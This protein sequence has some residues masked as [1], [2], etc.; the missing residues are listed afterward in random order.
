MT[1]LKALLNQRIKK[2]DNGSKMA[3]MAKQSATG[4][5]SSFSGIFGSAELSSHE[6]AYLESILQEYNQ[7]DEDVSKDL[8]QLSFITSEVKAINNQAALLHGE[9][10]KKAHGIFTRYRDGAF[11]AWL[12]ATYGN[13]QTP[14]NLMQY[15]EFYEVMPKELRPQLESMPRQAVYTLAS[16]N[17]DLKTKLRIVADFNGESKAELLTLIR[18]LFPLDREDRRRSSLG[19]N[20]INV[21]TKICHHLE[22]DHEPIGAS[23]KRA[24]KDLLDHIRSL[25]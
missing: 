4:N 25:V 6:R 20:V 17:G 7:G 24:I 13:R 14:Y 11:T 23:Q 1:D 15:Y 10:I 9:R 22:E 19:D 16:R 3:E 18:Q 5:R 8:E 21:L 12:I 2:A